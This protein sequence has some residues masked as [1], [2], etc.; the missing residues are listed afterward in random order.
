M[1]GLFVVGNAIY[2]KCSR[3]GKLIRWNKW[4]FGSLHVCEPD[5]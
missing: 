3:C 2:G 5:E 1:R 4:L